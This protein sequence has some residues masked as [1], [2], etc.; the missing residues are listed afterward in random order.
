MWQKDLGG[1]DAEEGNGCSVDK[2]KSKK[3]DD[4]S[5]AN[6]DDNGNA[7]ADGNGEARR[8]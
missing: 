8:R 3:G 5:D 6:A 4:N 1:Q 7:E 2:R